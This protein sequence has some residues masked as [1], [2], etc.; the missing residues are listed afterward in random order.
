MRKSSEGGL[1]NINLIFSV[2]SAAVT[3]GGLCVGLGVM[4]AKID[5]ATK[6]NKTQTKKIE[7]CVT[8]EEL[9]MVV[10]SI[11]EDR[12]HNAEQHKDFYDYRNRIVS[13]E[14]TL[15]SL[16]KS[17][18]EFK[19]DIKSDMREILSEVKELRRHT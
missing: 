17:F 11:D 10:R 9:G 4:K 19:L 6:V 14:S 2:I 12:K 5:R 3:V 8:K 16:T 7:G 15:K 18:D 13:I 1:M